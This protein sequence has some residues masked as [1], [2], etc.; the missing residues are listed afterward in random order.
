VGPEVA[1][2]H[3]GDEVYGLTNP[4][5]A[6]ANAEYAVASATTMAR[7]PRHLSHIDCAS[8]PVVAVTAWQMLFE[9]GEIA[10]GQTVLIL[11]AGG[12]V[13]AYAVQ[14]AVNAGLHVVAVA[15]PRDIEY[16]RSLG[17]GTLVDYRTPDFDRA[18]PKVDLVLDLV[19]GETLER[20]LGAL[21]PGGTLVSVVTTYPLPQRSEF[22]SV[23]FY[24]DVSTE[25]LNEISNLLVGGKLTSRVGTV[26]KL[27]EIRTAHEM[28]AGKPH[29]AG[30]IVLSIAGS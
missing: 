7:K 8:V 9:Y 14:L 17:A 18:I 16:V 24:A 2:F 5:F 11:G 23:S 26:L 27:E 4:Q 30:K 6:G 13:G 21:K 12:N 15:G 1:G 25:R 10:P 3:I 20:L 28:L 19:G 22:R 29:A